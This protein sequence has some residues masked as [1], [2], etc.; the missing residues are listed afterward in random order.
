MRAE[1]FLIMAPLF[2]GCAHAADDEPSICADRPGKANPTCTVPTGRVQVETGLVDWTHDRDSGVRTDLL[3]VAA[4]AIKY[5]LTDR[6]QV[7]VDVA[8]YNALRVHGIG[9]SE[10][11]TGFGD[12][13]IASKYRLT[14]GDGVQVALDPHVKIPTAAHALGNGRVEAG[15]AM[16]IDSAIPHSVLSVTLG[17]ELDWLADD[18]GRGHH[19][20]MVQVA[21]VGWQASDK[22]NLSGELWAQWNWDPAGTGRQ[23]SADAAAAYLVT[24]DLQLDAG[25]NF[26]LNRQTPDIELYAGVA[27][28]F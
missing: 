6:W 23:T 28:R 7:E 2:A 18:D 9:L 10:R 13:V 21:G 5:G 15:V 14:S 1:A 4:T 8:P 24:S 27:K 19:L 20:A 26:G 17:P 16:P 11:D 3:S 12:V 22:L 25:A